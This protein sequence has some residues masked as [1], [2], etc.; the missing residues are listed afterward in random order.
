MHGRLRILRATMF[1]FVSYSSLMV[2]LCF[3]FLLN[4]YLCFR[5]MRQIPNTYNWEEVTKK[6]V[7]HVLC[8]EIKMKLMETQPSGN[9]VLQFGLYGEGDASFDE[10]EGNR[11]IRRLLHTEGFLERYRIACLEDNGNRVEHIIEVQ[12]LVLEHVQQLTP[13][14]R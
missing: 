2:Y 4:N 3:H 5:F 9:D 10:S 14:M 11:K 1:Q 7:T 13:P 12:K 6:K 8:N